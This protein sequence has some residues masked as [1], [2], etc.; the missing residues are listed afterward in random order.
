MRAIHHFE[1]IISAYEPE[2]GPG[3][4]EV[5]DSL[6]H[7]AFRAEDE[8]GDAVVGVGDVFGGA[9]LHEAVDDLGVGETGVAENGAA[10]LEGLDDFIGLV[11][12]EGEAGG[13]GVD[14]HGAPEG[15]LGAGSHATA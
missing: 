4:L 10:G 8:R 12:R 9:D 6:S 1:H 13:G 14:F 5:V 2:S 11:A 15:L 7:I 3:G